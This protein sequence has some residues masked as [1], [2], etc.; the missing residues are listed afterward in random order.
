AGWGAT[1][2]GP[3]AG[4]GDGD[5]RGWGR[6]WHAPTITASVRGV[7][8]RLAALAGVPGP[9]LDTMTDRE[10]TLLSLTDPFWEEMWETEHMSHRPFTVDSSAIEET[11][12]IA[13][14]PLDDVL[15][16]ALSRM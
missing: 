16:E 1:P 12:G 8:D 3:C 10:L 13:A 2:G 4:G 14:S 9:R 11:F 5:E 7:A 15:K 6:P